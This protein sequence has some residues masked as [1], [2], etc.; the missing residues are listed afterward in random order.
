VY[1]KCPEGID[2]V[3]EGWDLSED[4]TELLQTIYGTKQ[5]A[6]QYWKMFMDMMEGK[7]FQ[8]T[9]ADPCLLKRK[10]E[11]GMVVV[12]VYIDDYLLTGDRP[13]IDAAMID[14]ESFLKLDAW[15]H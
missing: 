8:R 11:K 15:D 4:C 9:H 14:I 10:D 12:C 1:M 7:C 6:R 13:A 5:A 2:L 3:E